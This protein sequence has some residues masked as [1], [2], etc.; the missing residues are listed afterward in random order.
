[1]EKEE[2]KKREEEKRRLEDIKE[3]QIREL[4]EWLERKRELP[5]PRRARAVT[6]DR[7]KPGTRP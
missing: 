2:I 6:E 7:G 1:M 3:S 5:K 4:K